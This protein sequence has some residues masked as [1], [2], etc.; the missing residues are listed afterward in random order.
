MLQDSPAFSGFTVKNIA[1]AKSF[2]ENILGISVELDE[3]GLRLKCAGNTTIFVYEKPDHIPATY[4]I[5][6][7]PV[8]NINETIDTLVAKGITMER[9]NDLPAE[10]DDRGV[11]RGKSAQMGP[12]IA[13]FKDPS[14]NILSVLEN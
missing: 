6:N 13:W 2:Y 1:E 9:Y 7:F 3:M 12:D 8:L 4:T 10:Q 14:G 11:L 5:L